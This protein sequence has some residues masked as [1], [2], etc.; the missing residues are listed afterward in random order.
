MG[1]FDVLVGFA[2]G[3]LFTLLVLIL[4]GSR[5]RGLAHDL[6]LFI[7]LFRDLCATATGIL[8]ALQIL[9]GTRPKP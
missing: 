7:E 5:Q 2:V 1:G 4:C 6:G 9:A 3:V 8:H